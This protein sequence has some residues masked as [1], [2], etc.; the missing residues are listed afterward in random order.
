MAKLFVVQYCDVTPEN[1][2]VVDKREFYSI[3]AA[4]RQRFNDVFFMAEKNEDIFFDTN[5]IETIEFAT[6]AELVTALNNLNIVQS[7][8]KKKA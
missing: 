2:G 5:E 6:T 7:E 8:R 1:K 3:E 4:A